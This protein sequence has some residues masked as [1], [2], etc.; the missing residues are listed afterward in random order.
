MKLALFWRYRDGLINKSINIINNVNGCKDPNYKILST[1]SE[2]I[3]YKIKHR[4]MIKV[5]EGV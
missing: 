2:K 3:F 4:L 1:D 5:L